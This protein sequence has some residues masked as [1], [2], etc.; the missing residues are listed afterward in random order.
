MLILFN[1]RIY[2]QDDNRPFATA[3]AIRDDRIVA[4]GD[5]AD[6]LALSS[7]EDQIRNLQGKTILP[8]LVDAHIHLQG[9]AL[10]LQKINCETNTLQ[11][12]LQRVHQK[13]LQTP[14][15]EWILGHGW[16][17]NDWP[18]GYGTAQVLD[19]VSTDHPAYLTAKSLH[20]GW[21]NSLALQKA[22][23][24][25]D[26]PDSQD[27]MIQRDGKGN[28]TGILLENAMALVENVIPHPSISTIR[29]AI[30]S[31]QNQLWQMG[32]TGVHDYDGIDC[33]LS[34]QQIQ[35]DGQLHLRVAKGIPVEKLDQA[36]ALGLRS[37]F[38][39]DFIW[40]GS[41]KL[42][43]DGALG[44]KTAAM[45]SPYQGEE[46]YCGFPFL[47]QE[48]VFEIGQKSSPAG[49][50]LAIHAIGDRANHDV[51]NAF[52]QLR[53]FEEINGIQNLRH[54]IEHVQILHPDDLARLAKNRIIASM[55]PYHAPSD[56]FMADRH[57]GKRSRYAYPWN[58]LLAHNTILAFGSDA[59]VENPNPFWG[60]HA[61]INRTRPEDL[62]HTE[63]WIPE[64][65]ITIQQALDAYTIGAA[66]AANKDH[67]FG[68]LQKGYLA[69]LILLDEDI[70]RVPA[71][72][73]YSIQPAATMVNGMWVWMNMD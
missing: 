21:A 58:S 11:E 3:I 22:G 60:L 14:P 2:T 40:I 63:A 8:G 10:G 30:C 57:W 68:K 1:A 38:G 26:T 50:S 31:A 56:M 49:L 5:D 73:V 43:A 62:Q 16:N 51:I 17:H 20:A 6:I 15:G 70:F 72:L 41:V 45:L 19:Q 48:Q 71:N 39:N 23:I 59:P 37:G 34:L 47:D 4:V 69:D 7:S 29:N 55:Q 28:P 9:Y 12:C 42:F 13:A 54:R 24:T 25:S 66:Y 53:R 52:S 32:I 46:K 67:V 65:C 64:E 27:H 33:F 61:A 35:A 36:I 18:E 44:P